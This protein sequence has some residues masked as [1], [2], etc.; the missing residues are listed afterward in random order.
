[1]RWVAVA[2]LIAIAATVVGEGA[3]PR[4]QA[5]ATCGR[6]EGFLASAA[7]E[8]ALRGGGAL[9]GV[10]PA[11]VLVSFPPEHLAWPQLAALQ[12][13]AA[14]LQSTFAG[15]IE[16]RAWGRSRSDGGWRP[17]EASAAWRCETR[18]FGLLI[19]VDWAVPGLPPCTGRVPWRCPLQQVPGIDQ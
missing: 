18:T 17:F 9:S 7:F 16:I 11:V 10:P 5:V 6:G 15:T 14:R 4:L 13:Q 2:M 1:V 12:L 3:R 8:Q 19:G